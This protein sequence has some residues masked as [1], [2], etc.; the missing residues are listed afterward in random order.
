MHVC[1]EQVCG[2]SQLMMDPYYRTMKGFATMIE[3]EWLMF[4]HKFDERCG[5]KHRD[6]LKDEERSPIFYQFLD[7]VY[8][9][10]C[11]FPTQ[12]EFNPRFLCELMDEVHACRWRTFM[13]DCE[14]K[15]VEEF[16]R[17]AE[18]TTPN[19]WNYLFHPH[20]RA[21]LMN[22]RFKP[23]SAPEGRRYFSVKSA[24]ETLDEK[25]N[26]D[27]SD[28]EIDVM[29]SKNL[30]AFAKQRSSRRQREPMSSPSSLTKTV[31]VV[32]REE[33]KSAFIRGPTPLVPE[34]CSS[35]NLRLFF[36]YIRRWDVSLLQASE[37]KPYDIDL[38]ALCREVRGGVGAPSRKWRVLCIGVRKGAGSNF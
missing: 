13:R 15:R 9:I 25:E 38:L 37:D 10:M 19:V 33:E 7:C 2:L 36:P 5:N 26:A 35:Q 28:E 21:Q 27:E 29:H 4:G 34:S 16:G 32:A 12:F 14:G 23:E 11:Q 18:L 22:P 6:N 20:L 31:T 30:E 3:K 24:L 1:Y 17:D 8:Q